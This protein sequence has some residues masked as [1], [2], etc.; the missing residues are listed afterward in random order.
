MALPSD[1]VL[2]WDFD[3]KSD[4]VLKRRPL[5]H[6]FECRPLFHIDFTFGQ[7]VKGGS[8]RVHQLWGGG[9]RDYEVPYMLVLTFGCGITRDYRVSYMLILTLGQAA[10][11]D[12]GG[13]INVDLKCR[14]GDYGGH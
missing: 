8:F 1:L 6:L 5:F 9:L 14:A 10:T 3:L 4:I 13:P 12:D 11:G 7:G 2:R